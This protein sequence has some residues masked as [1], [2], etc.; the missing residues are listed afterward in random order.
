MEE[1]VNVCTTNSSSS[2]KLL[3]C[4][5]NWLQI[6]TG[7]SGKREMQFNSTREFLREL[8]RWNAQQPG[9]WQYFY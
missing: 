4:R 7:K 5:Y 8:N 9:V 2:K 6:S 1:F 3:T